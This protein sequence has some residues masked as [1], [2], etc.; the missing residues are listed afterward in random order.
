M[1][2]EPKRSDSTTA[3]A[4]WKTALTHIEPNKVLVRGYPLDEMMGRV[5]FGDAI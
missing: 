5:N 4:R 1:A 3:P 2:S